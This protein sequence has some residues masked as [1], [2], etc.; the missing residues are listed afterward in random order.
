MVILSL[1]VR[2]LHFFFLDL[3]ALARTPVSDL[4]WACRYF[5]LF[6]FKKNGFGI[7]GAIA[8]GF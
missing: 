2:V 3:A 7:S 5:C 4:N 1:P 6:E 8:V